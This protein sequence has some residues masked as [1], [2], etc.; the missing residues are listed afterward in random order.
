MEP[1]KGR[2]TWD[3]GSKSP[4]GKMWRLGEGAGW[5]LFPAQNPLGIG[6]ALICIP[7]NLRTSLPQLV[8]NSD[9]LFWEF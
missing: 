8:G 1:V 7:Q 4:Q 3:G 6:F 2:G 5:R 9:G